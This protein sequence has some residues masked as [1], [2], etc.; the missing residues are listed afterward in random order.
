M[1]L[2]PHHVHGAF[3]KLPSMFCC[4]HLY[5]VKSQYCTW[6]LWWVFDMLTFPYCGAFGIQVYQIP[7]IYHHICP[8]EGSGVGA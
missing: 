7:S 8:M 4:Y 5:E 3:D 2:L 6:S 1:K